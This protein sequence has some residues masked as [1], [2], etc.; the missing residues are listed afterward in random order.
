M[1]LTISIKEKKRYAAT[2]RKKKVGTK[3]FTQLLRGG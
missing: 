2:Q 3:L 1:V